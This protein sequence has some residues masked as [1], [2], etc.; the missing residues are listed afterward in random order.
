MLNDADLAAIAI[1]LKLAAT[2]TLILL[3]LGTPFDWLLA[4]TRWR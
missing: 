1:T 2:T 4:H 3:L